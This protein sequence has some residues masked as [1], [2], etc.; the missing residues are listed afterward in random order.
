MK[1]V[2]AQANS[3]PIILLYGC[4]GRGKTT[5]ASKFPNPLALLLERGLPK[6]TSIDA[7]EDAGTFDQVMN[8]LRAIYNDPGQYA[9]LVIDTVESLK[10]LRIQS[11]CAKNGWRTIETPSYGRGWVAADDEW[12]RFIKAIT[13]IRDRHAMAVVLVAHAGIERVDDPRAPSFT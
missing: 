12:R 7:V 10:A 13:A 5:L 4:E 6:G 9:T 1:I 11:L 2:K 8:A 3:M